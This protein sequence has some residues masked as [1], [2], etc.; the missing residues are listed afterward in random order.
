MRAARAQDRLTGVRF[1]YETAFK[2]EPVSNR[3][4]PSLPLSKPRPAGSPSLDAV[5]GQGG[6]PREGMEEEPVSS[7]WIDANEI[8]AEEV[9]RSGWPAFALRAH[10]GD[11]HT[12]VL[13]A[14]ETI[15]RPARIEEVMAVL[16]PYVRVAGD[17]CFNY[18]SQT[19]TCAINVPLDHRLLYG[20]RGAIDAGTVEVVFTGRDV[21]FALAQ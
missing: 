14:L 8:V 2:E 21:L 20:L 13:G 3:L 10:E 12:G 7:T 15:N 11:L 5:L 4:L 19:L 16:A 1:D 18:R 9:D 17:Q 6:F